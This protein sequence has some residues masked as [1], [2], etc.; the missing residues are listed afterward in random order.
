MK[1]EKTMNV[2]TAAQSTINIL[3][4][5]SHDHES[6]RDLKGQ[7]VGHAVWMLSGIILG[8]IQD[9]KAHRWLGYAQGILVAQ[10]KTTLEDVKNIN[11]N[12]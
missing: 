5:G 9:A 2:L 6:V 7:S 10:N 8:Y 11:R 12:S 4:D 1:K 3:I